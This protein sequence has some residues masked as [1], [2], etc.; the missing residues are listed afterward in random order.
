MPRPAPAEHYLRLDW[1]LEG[2][3]TVDRFPGGE[4]RGGGEIAGYAKIL[5]ARPH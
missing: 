3:L 1:R 4:G 5:S 2:V